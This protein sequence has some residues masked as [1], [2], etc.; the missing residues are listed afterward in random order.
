MLSC[1]PFSCAARQGGHC[2]GFAHGM[3]TCIALC[4]VHAC[5][6]IALLVAGLEAQLIAQH[7][8]WL[9]EHLICLPLCAPAKCENIEPFPRSLA[10]LPVFPL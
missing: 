3:Y 6:L 7:I 4:I 2:S 1:L 8:A 5:L 10:V 9:I